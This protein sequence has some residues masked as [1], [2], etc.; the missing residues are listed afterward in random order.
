MFF[1]IYFLN[2]Q[3]IIL[4]VLLKKEVDSRVQRATILDRIAVQIVVSFFLNYIE[5]KRK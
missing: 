1:P 2:H 3:K 4:L 5:L